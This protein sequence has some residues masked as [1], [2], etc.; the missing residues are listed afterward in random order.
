MFAGGKVA[1]LKIAYDC[2]EN[3]GKGISVN[4]GHPLDLYKAH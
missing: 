3:I 2:S 4:Q 1:K